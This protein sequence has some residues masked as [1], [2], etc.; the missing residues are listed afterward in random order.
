MTARL[1]KG[2]YGSEFR[3]TVGLF[4][5]FC[6]QMHPM[7]HTRMAKNS[8]WYNRLGERLGWGDLSTTNF[9]QISKDDELFIILGEQDSFWNLATKRGIISAQ[10]V[11]KPDVK[12][13]GVEYVAD[14][15]RFVI[16][17]GCVYIV[18]RFEGLHGEAV[19]VRNGVTLQVLSREEAKKL[20]ANS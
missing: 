7:L 14:H 17:K 8:G 19:K 15:C 12:A 6:G 13:P 11:A 9:Q 16:A 18:E 3:T 20:I 10:A 1:T 4:G 5:L 2:M